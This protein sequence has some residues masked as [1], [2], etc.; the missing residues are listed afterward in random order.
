MALEHHIGR[1]LNGVEVVDKDL[2]LGCTRE[3]V[4]TVRELDLITVLG[5]N[6]LREGYFVAQYV[7]D[8]D[9]V[10]ECHDQMQAARMECNG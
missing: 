2:M 6:G 1:I 10:T 3:E 8:R 9:L 7:A 5:W 4:A